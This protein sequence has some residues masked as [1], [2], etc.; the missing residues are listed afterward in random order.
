MLRYRRT[1]YSPEAPSDRASRL[2]FLLQHIKDLAP[3]RIGNS[4]IGNI[5]VF[6]M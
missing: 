4:M 1:A 2:A 3:G 6:H 5:G